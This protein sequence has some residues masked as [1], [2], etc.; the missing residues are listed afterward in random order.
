MADEDAEE[1][2]EWD[3]LR[4]RDDEEMGF[5]TELALHETE[6]WIQAITRKKFEYADDFRKSL[7][8]GVLLCE[9]LNN[10]QAGTIKRINK[11]PGAIAGLDNVNVFLAACEKTFGLKPTQ[12]F[13]SS[14]LEDLTQRAI[15]DENEYLLKQETERRSRNVAVT[16]YWLAKAVSGKF[17][18]PSLDTSA[19]SALVYTHGS[20]RDSIIADEC[21]KNGSPLGKDSGL[22]TV[23]ET[24]DKNNHIRD[25]SY[26]SLGSYERESE[27]SFDELDSSGNMPVRSDM[28][29]MK[30][31]GSH[32]SLTLPRDLKLSS[33]SQDSMYSNHKD[34]SM[35]RSSPDI[36]HVHTRSSSTDSAEGG[37]YGNHSRQSSGS[38]AEYP[39]RRTSSSG[40][41][42]SSSSPDPLQFVKLRSAANLAEQAKKQIEVVKEVNTMRGLTTAAAPTPLTHD[43]PDW[44]SN[45]TKWKT[46]RRKSAHLPDMD[47]NAPL[48]EEEPRKQKTFSQIMAEKEDRKSQRR[49]INV[50]PM[51]DDDDLTG[52][53]S[54]VSPVTKTSTSKSFIPKEPQV[55]APWAQGSSGEDI[56]Q[57]DSENQS[58]NSG[59]SDSVFSSSD[60]SS[61]PNKVLSDDDL[62]HKNKPNSQIMPNKVIQLNA[63]KPGEGVKK[64]WENN[65]NESQRKE[66]NK[67]KDIPTNNSAKIKNI[68]HAFEQ[69][70]K[71][72]N[73]SP[74]IKRSEYRNSPPLKSLDLSDSKFSP[75][76]DK[77]PVS[78][79]SPTTPKAL[80]PRAD[81]FSSGRNVAESNNSE[82]EKKFVQKVIKISQRPNNNRGFG[83]TLVGGL[84][85]REPVTVSRVSLGSAADVQDVLAN[86][87]LV[88]VNGRDVWTLTLAQVQGIIDHGVKKG[89]IELKVK[90]YTDE[91]AYDSMEEEEANRQANNNN[92]NN[93]MSNKV[94]PV[95]SS[96]ETE[97]TEERHGYRHHVAQIPVKTDETGKPR[98]MDQLLGEQQRESNNNIEK[99]ARAPSPVAME[100]IMPKTHVTV[101]TTPMRPGLDGT[102]DM[103]SPGDLTVTEERPTLSI[104]KSPPVI[105]REK[106]PMLPQ[107]SSPAPPSPPKVDPPHMDRRQDNMSTASEDSNS[108]GF[109]PPAALLRWQ[110]RRPQ[111][112]NVNSGPTME[113]RERDRMKRL[114]S[115]LPYKSDG[116]FSFDDKYSKDDSEVDRVSKDFVE[117][118][119]VS[120]SYESKPQAFQ[121]NDESKMDEW[122]NRQEKERKPEPVKSFAPI[123][124]HIPR[125]ED[126]TA[127]EK[128]EREQQRIRAKYEEE[129]RRASEAE[130]QKQEQEKK[131]LD[132]DK[133]LR[134]MESQILQTKT[135]ASNQN[136]LNDGSGRSLAPEQRVISET[137]IKFPANAPARPLIIDPRNETASLDPKMPEYSFRVDLSRT[138]TAPPLRTLN[139]QPEL[140]AEELLNRER[141]KIRA[142]EKMK[143]EEE[144]LRWKEEQERKNQEQEEKLRQERERLQREQERIER[145]RAMLEQ[146]KH[147]EQTTHSF[148]PVSNQSPVSSTTSSLSHSPRS[149]PPAL[150]PT[151]ANNYGKKV[152]PPTAPK[153]EK[154]TK[155]K[156]RLTREDLLAMN[157]KATPLTKPDPSMEGHHPT[158]DSLSPTMREA[159]TK[160]QLHS[161][162]AVPK[163]K[164]RH[165]APW[166]KEED[167]A[168]SSTQSEKP[169]VIGKRSD[170]IH[171]RDYSN[172]NDHWVV[173]EAEKRRLA[174]KRDNVESITARAGPT[175]PSQSALVSRF[176]SDVEPPP[177][178]RA[179]RYSYPS[180]S[181]KNDTTSSRLSSTSGS[182]LRNIDRSPEQGITTQFSAR[183]Q[184][185]S[186]ASNPSMSSTLPPNFSFNAN[187]RNH[188]SAGSSKPP[189]SL[190]DNSDSVIAVSG[191]QKCSHCGEELVEN[192]SHLQ[193]DFLEGFGAAMV[194]ESLGLYYHVQCFRCCVC[195]M[196]LGNGSEGADVRVR[197][198]K[199][200]CKNCYSNDE[201]GLK[202][203]KV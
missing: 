53:K 59:E 173:R 94:V 171:Q 200:H 158:S 138:E 47:V 131:V 120:K 31:Y 56:D 11:L 91:E 183:T 133:F 100:T 38:T 135:E 8:N 122:E 80:T 114:S 193:C 159:P 36:S 118:V 60:K 196:A 61:T 58:H 149:P 1:G 26:D 72:A 116:I 6:R 181:D 130:R 201:A 182:S 189:R 65:V 32:S 66:N 115:T 142:E 42:T 49:P 9:L 29:E 136:F 106:S 70:D 83:F 28:R 5:F 107:Q 117:T 194:I 195:H 96:P 3:A 155:E 134:S 186:Y 40:R 154:G 163:Q 89:Q 180:Y 52:K 110:R 54:S 93:S 105:R 92:T 141:E 170:L 39:T 104:R 77:L 23:G 48:E 82:P 168:G 98:L 46:Q 147:E 75:A 178:S 140:S 25:S 153:P 103:S 177:R 160:A 87:E 162:N 126:L 22:E 74:V 202:F 146:K 69:K 165:S 19:F 192:M 13:D 50:Y 62:W 187:T 15:A 64:M 57:S 125:E 111:S 143:F 119:S 128:F 129:K 179:N 17:N 174:D 152:P 24:V 90:R 79:L 198:D 14:D 43:E 21:F 99:P 44:K 34:D 188:A 190:S 137:T 101:E 132:S 203:S 102:Q 20:K 166:M 7:G 33:N 30:R 112:E 67:K 68:T 81:R 144:R 86:D 45:L 76:N 78:P 127:Q 172:P 41:K 84:E 55:V 10:L 184:P 197:V 156:A 51:D 191:K 97:P 18:G 175:K 157:R 169:F 88:E 95:P 113:D 109:G 124:L 185:N 37:Y 123:E 167:S 27:S 199:L 108:S 161:L 121:F 12:L 73:A 71:E 2:Q 164:Y 63:R 35:Y 150:N 85:K 139:Q 151:R 4:M 148:S 145:E 176:R 16:I